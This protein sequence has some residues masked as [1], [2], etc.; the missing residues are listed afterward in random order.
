MAMSSRERY[1]SIAVLVA[2]SAFA[3][4]RLFLSPY[5]ERR[6]ALAEEMTNRDR[7]LGDAQQMLQRERQ[8]RQIMRGMGGSLR[9][10]ASAVEGQLL[11]LLHEWQQQAGV[12]GASFQR[13]HALEAHGFTHLKYNI[14]AAGSMP[15]IAMLVYR[16]ETAPI[17]LRVDDIHVTPKRETGDELQVQ[18]VISTL[19]RTST[20]GNPLEREPAPGVAL[21]RETGGTP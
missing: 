1:I 13:V 10:D 15:A 5:L 9:A 19:G 2:A 17:P 12:G 20:G 6:K 8:L 14:S 18:L 7:T 11:H 21:L 3:I 4:D 16:V